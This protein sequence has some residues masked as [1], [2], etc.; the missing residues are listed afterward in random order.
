[1]GGD[2]PSLSNNFADLDFLGL[3]QRRVA[4]LNTDAQQRAFQLFNMKSA[5]N[6]AEN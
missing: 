1:M 4:H 2:T 6:S 5:N 3:N